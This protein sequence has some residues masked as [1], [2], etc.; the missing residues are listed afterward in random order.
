[1]KSILPIL[2]VSGL[3]FGAATVARSEVRHALLIGVWRYSDP[4]YPPL[5]Q[6]AIEG[7]VATMEGKL[8]QLGFELTVVRN[9]NL[10]EAKAAWHMLVL[11]Y[12]PRQRV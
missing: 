7:D 8:K 10:Q 12:R 5:P 3:I 9:P 4:T 2:I 1:M 11:L 6:T